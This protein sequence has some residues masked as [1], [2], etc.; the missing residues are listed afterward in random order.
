[1]D[2]GAGFGASGALEGGIGDVRCDGR[3]DS[4]NGVQRKLR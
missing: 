2:E 1:M 4:Y 3:D